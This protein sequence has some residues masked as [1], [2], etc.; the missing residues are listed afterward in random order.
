MRRRHGY[1]ASA[2]ENARLLL[3][4]LGIGQ[5]TGGVKLGKLLEPANGV[6]VE[7]A[8]S[9]SGSGGRGFHG[10]GRCGRGLAGAATATGHR[11]G[12]TDDNR[13][14]ACCLGGA[15]GDAADTAGAAATGSEHRDPR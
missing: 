8:S 1:S 15:A 11:V 10:M 3:G 12:G 14:V 2:R 5:H 9:G 4:K 13:G 7:A 6:V